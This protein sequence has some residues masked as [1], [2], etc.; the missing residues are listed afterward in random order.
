[1][2]G[3]AVAH[4][5]VHT[6]MSTPTESEPRTAYGTIF[7]ERGTRRLVIAAALL[8]AAWFAFSAIRTQQMRQVKW[9]AL[10][11]L[12][13]G[14]TVLGLQ[15]KDRPGHPRRYMAIEANRS[16]Q[17][18]VPDDAV[19]VGEDESATPERTEGGDDR[20]QVASINNRSAGGR[21]VP[22]EEV[23][24]NSPVVLTG[25]H[26][27]SA[28]VEERKDPFL[29]RT[30]FVVHVGLTDEGRSR[31]WQFSRE[32]EQERLVFVLSNEVITCPK[33]VHMDVSSLT[34]DPIW[35][36][37]DAEK[38]AEAINKRGAAKGS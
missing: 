24:R 17:F 8:A 36:K 26:F 35:V 28:Q 19:D 5:S 3:T 20:G 11:A 23:M 27:T 33:M 21:L 38:L 22:L 1:M 4:R 31:Y 34:I 29:E 2:P 12:P 10:Q 7:R 14:L 9:P 25:A 16:W 15:D 6:R 13:D 37:V 32:H 18:R 30:Y